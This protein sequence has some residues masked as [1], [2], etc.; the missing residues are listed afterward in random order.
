MVLVGIKQ[1]LSPPR[2]GTILQSL[3]ENL[4]SFEAFLQEP[5]Q[6]ELKEAFRLT[7]V[8]LDIPESH[9]DGVTLYCRFT[10]QALA[11]L[12]MLD[13]SLKRAHADDL[14]SAKQSKETSSAA[15]TPVPP[16]TPKA[17]LSP[18]EEKNIFTL[19]QFVISLGIFPFLLP[20][21][22]NLL[23]LKL[24]EMASQL[25]KS[26]SLLTT[27]ACY[28]YH[29]SNTLT[30]LFTTPVIGA[31]ILSRHLSDV[32]AALLQTCHG[33][34]ETAVVDDQATHPVLNEV[35]RQWCREKLT[36]LLSTLHQPLVVRELLSLQSA[37]RKSADVSKRSHS[38]RETVTPRWLQSA[39][40]RLLSERLMQKDGL[41]TVL[42][43]I[44]DAIQG[45]SLTL[46]FPTTCTLPL[47][48]QGGGGAGEWKKVQ[49]VA[50]ILS[51]CPSQASS[52]SHYYTTISPQVISYSLD[53]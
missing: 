33:P 50:H 1:L 27:K 29:S 4:D 23:H 28:L 16:P 30:L 41:H 35:Q 46:K 2:E 44:F 8:S 47:S 9:E 7:S 17:L 43:G 15:K 45:Q 39:C 36:N 21:A 32:L 53:R 52:M 22:D 19:L 5:S 10:A 25:R 14:V 42:L 26:C 24:G 40:G 12:R 34:K 18:L 20:G 3:E 11:L 48:P 37:P 13:E 51:S 6:A 31:N 49:A 38:G